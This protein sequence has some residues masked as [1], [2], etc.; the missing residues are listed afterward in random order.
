MSLKSI[1]Y[2]ALISYPQQLIEMAVAEMINS[3]DYP[4]APSLI[5]KACE[6]RKQTD[7]E[8][9]YKGRK[10]LP[11]LE[12]TE[13]E[14]MIARKTADEAIQEMRRNLHLKQKYRVT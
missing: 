8:A 12:K 10:E 6:S 7:W 14:T 3:C 2:R 9:I 11:V 1:Y 4:P 13:S 5:V